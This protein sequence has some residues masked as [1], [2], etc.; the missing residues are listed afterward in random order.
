MLA[1]LALAALAIDADRS[2][3]L[4]RTQLSALASMRTESVTIPDVAGVLRSAKGWSALT[5]N[6]VGGH[7]ALLQPAV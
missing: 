7:L 5:V 6:K 1:C 3:S 2:T 4:R